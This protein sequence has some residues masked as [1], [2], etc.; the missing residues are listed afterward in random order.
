MWQFDLEEMDAAVVKRL[1]IHFDQADG[2]FAPGEVQMLPLQGYT[3]IFGEILKHPNIQVSTNISFDHAMLPD[4]AFC[5][6]RNAN[7]RIFRIQPG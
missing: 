4:Y 6:K 5:F 1:P 7:R 2:Y 3:S